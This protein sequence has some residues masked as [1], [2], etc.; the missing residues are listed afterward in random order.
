MLFIQQI[1]L[2]CLADLWADQA[3]PRDDTRSLS[4]GGGRGRGVVV[5]WLP[6]AVAAT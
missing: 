1:L 5:V 4:R 2:C 6:A 3:S